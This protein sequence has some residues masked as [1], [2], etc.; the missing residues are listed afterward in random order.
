M[1]KSGDLIRAIDIESV[2]SAATRLGVTRQRIHQMIDEGKIDY[3]EY[4]KRRM[5]HK[6]DIDRLII[7]GWPGKR[8]KRAS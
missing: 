6:R 7:N 1:K 8:T 5:L 4:G 3:Y 2:T